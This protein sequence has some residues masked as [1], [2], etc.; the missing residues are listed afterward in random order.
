MG[1]MKSSQ[2]IFDKG[3][4]LQKF[5]KLTNSQYHW[6]FATKKRFSTLTVHSLFAKT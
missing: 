5:C 1:K 4:I 3:R 2:Q 6:L